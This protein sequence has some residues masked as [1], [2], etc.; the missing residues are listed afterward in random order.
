MGSPAAGIS[1]SGGGA[2]GVQAAKNTPRQ[3]MI[4]TGRV[5]LV[6]I[7]YWSGGIWSVENHADLI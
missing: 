4:A 6:D 3:I 2:A 5:Y 1:G 7:G